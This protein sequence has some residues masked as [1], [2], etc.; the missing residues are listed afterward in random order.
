MRSF[1]IGDLG[2]LCHGRIL[3]QLGSFSPLLRVRDKMP[4][5]TPSVQTCR[6]HSFRAPIKSHHCHRGA[7]GQHMQQDE[8][9]GSEQHGSIIIN[10]LSDSG[11][12]RRG[13]VDVPETGGP[14]F[15]NR[16]IMLHVVSVASRRREVHQA[17]PFACPAI[18]T[19]R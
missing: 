16:Q 7:N 13:K 11:I 4:A 1:G 19:P 5:L 15:W 9:G 18:A 12:K 17:S 6:S 2:H 14:N 3:Y 10:A 8:N